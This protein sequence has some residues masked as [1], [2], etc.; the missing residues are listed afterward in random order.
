MNELSTKAVQLFQSA[1][2]LPRVNS[3]QFVWQSVIVKRSRRLWNSASRQKGSKSAKNPHDTN[4][5]NNRY[6]ARNAISTRLIKPAINK[7]ELFCLWNKF[8]RSFCLLLIAD[9]CQ[10]VFLH[11]FE[12]APKV[13]S[14]L[15]CARGLFIISHTLRWLARGK[16]STALALK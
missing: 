5:V 14:R 13:V 6:R 16:V 11:V 3:V 7:R 10:P 15:S 12:R 2:K 9:N 1:K 8:F 4:A